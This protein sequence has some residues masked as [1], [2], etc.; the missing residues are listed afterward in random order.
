MDLLKSTSSLHN[1]TPILYTKQNPKPNRF[2]KYMITPL[3]IWHHPFWLILDGSLCEDLGFFHS[4]KTS[5]RSLKSEFVWK[6]Y[7]CFTFGMLAVFCGAGSSG[8]P[9]SSGVRKF[10]EGSGKS[11]GLNRKF[12]YI[13]PKGARKFRDFRRFRGPEVP[14]IPGSSGLR[15][16]VCN[17]QIWWGTI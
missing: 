6:S 14:G 12:P 1:S 5:P 11:S 4:F 8:H 2:P 15:F 9:G 17:G 10:R 7:A 3:H 16:S 13:W